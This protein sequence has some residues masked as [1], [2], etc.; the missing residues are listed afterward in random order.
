MPVPVRYHVRSL[1]VRRTATALTVLA[2]GFSVATLVLVLALARGFEKTLAETGRADNVIFLRKGATSEGESGID[3]EAMRILAA[4]PN[5]AKGA[6]GRV[7]AAGEMY[8]GINLDKEGGGSTNVS[9]R[10]TSEW[11]LELR[12]QVRV[13]EGRMFREGTEEVVVGK[14]LVARLQGLRGG[15]RDGEL[16]R[17]EFAGRSL[18]IVGVIEAGGSAPE[19]EIWGDALVLLDIFKRESFSTVFARLADPAGYPAVEQAIAGDA[20]LQVRVDTERDYFRKQAGPQ[21]FV[22]RFMAWFLAGI[23]AVGAVFGSTNTLLASLAGRSREIGTLLAIGYR[24][25]HVMAGF[26]IEAGVIGLAGGVVGVAMAWP[27]NGLATGTTNWATFTEQAFAFAITGDVVL[28]AILFAGF[29]G[30]AGGVVP[31]LRA[32]LL[33][34]TRALRA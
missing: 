4:L 20:R 3:R 22:F 23:M 16:G 29:V 13:V 11:V 31:A 32:S 27:V 12:D 18:P 19:S 26:L 28:E 21:G 1:A 10:G 9:V 14:S 24:P 2:V 6:G 34:P 8:A 30:V 17:L 7:L 15:G 33:P 5:V 25:W